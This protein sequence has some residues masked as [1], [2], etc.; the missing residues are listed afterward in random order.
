MDTLQ[1]SSPEYCWESVT[2]PNWP[3]QQ[4]VLQTLLSTNTRKWTLI[5]EGCFQTLCLLL[6]ANDTHALL[7]GKGLE[8]HSKTAATH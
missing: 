2:D 7:L 5:L 3:R 6:S 8:E 4:T 1:E